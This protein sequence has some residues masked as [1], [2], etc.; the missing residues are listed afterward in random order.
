[1]VASAISARIPDPINGLNWLCIAATLSTFLGA[2]AEAGAVT[3]IP[4]NGMVITQDT[5]FEPGTYILPDGVSIGLPLRKS[6]VVEDHD[7]DSLGPRRCLRPSAAGLCLEGMT[8]APND[9]R[10]VSERKRTRPRGSLSF[11]SL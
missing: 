1:M 9:G 8:L 5:T 11:A 6:L 7:L 4:I 3:V 2:A 10:G